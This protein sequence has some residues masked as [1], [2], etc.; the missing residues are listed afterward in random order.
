LR[1]SLRILPVSTVSSKSDT[2]IGFK[3]DEC[4]VH[5]EEGDK[6]IK[7]LIVAWCDRKLDEGD[8]YFALIGD[9]IGD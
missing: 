3:V 4:V 8:S 7:N 5:I 2:L 9:I 1:R 6:C